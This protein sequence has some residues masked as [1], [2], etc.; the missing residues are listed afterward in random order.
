[1]QLGYSPCEPGGGNKSFGTIEPDADSVAV[2]GGGAGTAYAY[3]DADVAGEDVRVGGS[4]R[5]G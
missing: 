2:T 5:V 1:M 4:E 3:A